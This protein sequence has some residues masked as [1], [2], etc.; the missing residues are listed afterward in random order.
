MSGLHEL[1]RQRRLMIVQ[2]CLDKAQTVDDI[3]EWF[4]AREGDCEGI[5]A[6]VYGARKRG[7]ICSTAEHVGAG[8]KAVF[9]ATQA[10]IE[11]L[12]VDE[13]APQRLTRWDATELLRAWAGVA[14]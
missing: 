2:L 14:G 13:Q 4:L 3:E 5:R 11:L 7:L 9:T 1:G 12:G 6:A 10:G 8:H